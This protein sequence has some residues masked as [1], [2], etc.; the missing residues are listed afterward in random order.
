[1]KKP[2]L[3]LSKPLLGKEIPKIEKTYRSEWLSRGDGNYS[4]RITLLKNVVGVRARVHYL[5]EL[6]GREFGMLVG[7]RFRGYTIRVVVGNECR[8]MDSFGAFDHSK[9]S[10]M[11]I[12]MGLQKLFTCCWFDIEVVE[13]NFVQ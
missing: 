10:L 3:K 7:N 11:L 6:L 12:D 9:I 1:M 2:V 8:N 5:D 13:L 4:V